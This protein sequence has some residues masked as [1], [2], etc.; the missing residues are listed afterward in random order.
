[1]AEQPPSYGVVLVTASSQTEAEAI[2]Q[3]L[4]QARLAA[5]ISL[6]PMRSLYTWQ[7]EVHNDQEWQLLIKT[8]LSQFSQLAAQI[9]AI[10][11]YELPEIIALPILTGSPDYLEW[12]GAQLK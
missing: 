5:C 10:H 6:F 8:D 3:S 12:I 9:K 7:G 4:L 1:M 2:A 11:S